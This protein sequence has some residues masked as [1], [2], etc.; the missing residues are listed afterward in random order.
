MKLISYSLYGNIEKF[1]LGAIQ[2]AKIGKSLFP[3]WNQRFHIEV[4][5]DEAVIKIL[6]SLGMEV[7][8][9]EKSVGHGG[10]FWRFLPVTEL[11]IERVL[12]RDCD[13]RISAREKHLI[14]IWLDSNAPL[15][16]IRDHP[17]HDAP[18]LGGLWGV[19][20]RELPNFSMNLNSYKPTG[21]YG[22]DQEFLTKNV[23]SHLRD[24]ALI[25]DAYF[26][27]EPNRVR[28]HIE[29]TDGEFIG[30]SYNALEIPNSKHRRISARAESSKYT[31]L[32]I[33]V[34]SFFR[35]VLS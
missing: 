19:I 32:S 5:T 11:N 8:I 31:R 18:I 28:I 35:K 1:N 7:R 22:E 2:N 24:A 3:D 16:I 27:R 10:M 29:R 33:K 21:F 15:H 30:E 4:G 26:S 20:P 13:S 23:Y 34:K 17:M 12:V 25:H 6:R 14:E 9:M